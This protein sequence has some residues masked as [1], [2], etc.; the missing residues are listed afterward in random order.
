M[1]DELQALEKTR[2]WD[3]VDLPT[4]KP[5]VGCKWVYKIKTQS[6][7]F[8]ERYKAHLVAKG[9][10]Q[11]YRIDYEETFAPVAR[12]TLVCSLI[13]IAIAKGWKL[14]Q[15][16]VKNAFLNGDLAEE[17]YMKPP[18]KIEHPPNRVCQLK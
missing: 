18:P 9:F 7:G 1:Q 2:T 16:N 10:T 6:D 17:G 11:V 8:M 5:L 13:S 4:G 3:L 15:M 12:P 14:F